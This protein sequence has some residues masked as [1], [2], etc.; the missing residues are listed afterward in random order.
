MRCFLPYLT[1][2]KMSLVFFISVECSTK[3]VAN[4]GLFVFIANAF[5]FHHVRLGKHF[6]FLG[7]ILLLK[8][9]KIKN[10]K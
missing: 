4:I 3:T 8:E 1:R 10:K 5:L 7:A 6:N 2:C 9:N